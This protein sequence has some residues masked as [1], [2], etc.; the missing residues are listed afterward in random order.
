MNLAAEFFLLSDYDGPQ[1]QGH[2][3]WY[4]VALSLLVAVLSSCAALHMVRRARAER[5]RSVRQLAL[6]SSAFVLGGGVWAG[7]STPSTRPPVG[8]SP[9]R[10]VPPRPSTGC[11]AGPCQPCCNWHRCGPRALPSIRA[12][13]STA[14]GRRTPLHPRATTTTCQWPAPARRRSHRVT[15]VRSISPAC[16]PDRSP[17]L[18]GAGVSARKGVGAR[19]GRVQMALSSAA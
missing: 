18:A 6:A 17:R 2:Y 15:P 7:F 12:G 19:A 3:A 16:I 14:N 8:S 5:D 1:L 4:L 13:Y 11:P 9:I 10:P